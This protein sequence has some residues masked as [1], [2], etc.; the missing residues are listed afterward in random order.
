MSGMPVVEIS[1]LL[2]TYNRGHILTRAIESVLK[3]TFSFWELL[4]LDDG[5]SDNTELTVQKYLLDK[6]IKYFK[7]EHKGQMP[8]LNFGVQKASGAIISFID[9]DD[10]YD[11]NHLEIGLKCFEDYKNVE[12]VKTKTTVIGDRCVLDMNDMSQKIDIEDCNPQGTFLI[13]RNLINRLGGLPEVEYGPDYIFYKLAKDSGVK[14]K[15]LENKT[16]F[17]DR[18]G[19]DSITKKAWVANIKK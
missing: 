10:W 7:L 12:F 6:R 5:S 15:S 3:Q 14:I 16:Y 1:V 17:F 2:P 19:N 13:K 18:T 4:I 9:S 8:S 11:V